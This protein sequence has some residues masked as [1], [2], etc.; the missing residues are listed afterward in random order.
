MTAQTEQ[1]PATR[2]YSPAQAAYR[3]A[4]TAFSAA[5][6]EYGDADNYLMDEL[7]AGNITF[8]EYAEKTTTLEDM[9]VGEAKAA[10]DKAAQELI[11]WALG[12]V[13]SEQPELW[14]VQYNVIKIAL[15]GAKER[16]AIRERLISLCMKLKPAR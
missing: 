4:H 3:K 16:P 14:S 6:K 2:P 10:L 8:D 15:D 5:L 7:D 13:K 1:Y 11:D 9:I 12:V